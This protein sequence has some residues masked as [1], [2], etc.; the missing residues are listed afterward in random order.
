MLFPHNG[1]GVTT[2]EAASAWSHMARAYAPSRTGQ[3][4][5]EDAE[6]SPVGKVV[7]GLP[8]RRQA[9][10]GTHVS[11]FRRQYSKASIG[12][13]EALLQRCRSGCCSGAWISPCSTTRH[14]PSNSNTSAYCRTR[15]TS[16][17]VVATSTQR[18]LTRLAQRTIELIKSEIA[19]DTLT[20]QRRPK[21]RHMTYLYILTSKKREK[22]ETQ[23]V[24]THFLVGL[25]A[26]VSVSLNAFAGNIQPSRCA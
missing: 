10:D 25:A 14:R 20:R 22:D 13:V 8:Q 11:Q 17:L 26:A 3:Q 12:I 5:L 4:E 16:H 9:P 21:A 15:H 7:V 23:R 18:P 1:R 19:R 6:I 2:T 24:V